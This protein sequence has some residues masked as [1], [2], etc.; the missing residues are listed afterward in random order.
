MEAV[1]R[2]A[3]RTCACRTVRPCRPSRPVSKRLARLARSCAPEGRKPSVEPT[4]DLGVAEGGAGG[5]GG[6]SLVAGAS[7]LTRLAGEIMRR[8][9]AMISSI[10]G[11]WALAGWVMGCVL[12]AGNPAR[13]MNGQRESIRAA[14]PEYEVGREGCKQTQESARA[15]PIKKSVTVTS[16][17]GCA[18]QP[19]RHGSVDNGSWDHK[20]RP[21][22]RSTTGDSRP[23]AARRA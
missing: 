1:Q 14:S 18:L 21:G 8:M 5:D 16:H 13:P 19:R 11:S 20:P 7:S 9:E 2:T 10:G 6:S 15:T 17:P 12:A 22:R 3:R 23:T 4:L